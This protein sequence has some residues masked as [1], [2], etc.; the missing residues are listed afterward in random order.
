[1]SRKRYTPE[2][3]G[4]LYNMRLGMR[5]ALVVE[6]FLVNK[7]MVLERFSDVTSFGKSRHLCDCGTRQCHRNN[8][9]AEI[10]VSSR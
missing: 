9:R 1:M 6:R 7:G 8:R 2:R 4:Y 10:V 5:R 3:G